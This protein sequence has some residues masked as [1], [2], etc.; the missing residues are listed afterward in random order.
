M[1]LRNN[2]IVNHRSDM[3]SVGSEV[4][5]MD[6]Q[7]DEVSDS[8]RQVVEMS[9]QVD[10]AIDEENSKEVRSVEKEAVIPPD[11]IQLLIQSINEKMEKSQNSLR[12]SITEKM[13]ENQNSLRE[14]IAERMREE[15]QSNLQK[16]QNSLKEECRNIRLDNQRG[17]LLVRQI[18]IVPTCMK[19]KI[20][21]RK[22]QG[23]KLEN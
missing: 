5:R 23:K 2:K 13:E 16:M 20:G 3:A 21:Y 17:D 10:L 4:F 22:M 8:Q 7:E 12:E 19:W 6:S 14:S 11:M 18:S 15:N 9:S 1:R